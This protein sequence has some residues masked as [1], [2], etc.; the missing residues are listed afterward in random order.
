MSISE[1]MPSRK[2]AIVISMC[3]WL[4]ACKSS[5]PIRTQATAEESRQLATTIRAGDPNVGSQFLSGVGSIEASAWRWANPHFAVALG[6]PPGADKN[7]ATLT[8]AFN[9][10][11]VSI[12]N[13]KELTVS[14]KAGDLALEPQ[15]Y[16]TAGAQT[17]KR[18]LPASVFKSDALQVQ[19]DVDKFLQSDVDKRKLSLVVTAVQ[20]DPK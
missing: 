12:K 19:F 8:L 9:L 17:Y 13:L 10:P 2:L 7:G 4:C 3:G 6:V 14:G 18:D 11:D 16:N 1:L 5:D 20:L 15:T